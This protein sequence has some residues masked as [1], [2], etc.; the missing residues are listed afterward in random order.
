MVVF[1]ARQSDIEPDGRPRVL[2]A[3]GFH[4]YQDMLVAYAGDYSI[5]RKSTRLLARTA[6]DGRIWTEVQ[7]CTCR[8]A[9][10]MGRRRPSRGG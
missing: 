6:R 7:T 4:I 2:T 9:P 8:S 1:S 5:D 3:A 10:T